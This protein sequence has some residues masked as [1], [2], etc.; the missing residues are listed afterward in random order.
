MMTGPILSSRSSFD[1]VN[2]TYG[3]FE[4][5]NRARTI[6][7]IQLQK[8]VVIIKLQILLILIVY[9]LMGRRLAM[10]S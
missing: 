9:E 6:N 8:S 1:Q 10:Y 7:G 4:S 5:S 2:G 3:K